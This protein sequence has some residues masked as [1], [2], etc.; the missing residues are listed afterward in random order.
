MTN[1]QLVEQIAR[2]LDACD[3]DKVNHEL[4]LKQA[5]AILPFILAA[6]EEGA[7]A[8]QEAAMQKLI[9]RLETQYTITVKP[10]SG[11]ERTITIPGNME[12]AQALRDLKASADA[13]E[14]ALERIKEIGERSNSDYTVC[15]DCFDAEREASKALVAYR[16]KFGA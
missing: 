16:E 15:P 3:P 4:C 14:Q 7:R 8:M 2:V 6:R 10:F 9:E 12:A 13:M 11:P 5:R 1:E